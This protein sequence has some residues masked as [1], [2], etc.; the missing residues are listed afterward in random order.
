M[1]ANDTKLP[2]VCWDISFNHSDKTVPAFI[3]Q[4]APGNTGLMTWLTVISGKKNKTQKSEVIHI[5]LTA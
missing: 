4:V 1:M 2:A 3:T 5:N